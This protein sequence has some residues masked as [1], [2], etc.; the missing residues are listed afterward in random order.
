[1]LT[2]LWKC[3]P[4]LLE[5][6]NSQQQIPTCFLQASNAAI[7]GVAPVVGAWHEPTANSEVQ[8]YPQVRSFIRMPPRNVL[9]FGR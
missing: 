4:L 9:L 6:S 1:M 2:D 8:A 7:T 3:N 5:G